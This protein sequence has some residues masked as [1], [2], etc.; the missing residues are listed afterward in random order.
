MAAGV[1]SPQ[2]LRALQVAE[3]AL[4]PQLERQLA[5]RLT[6]VAVAV[7]QEPVEVLLE[8][9]DRVLWSLSIQTQLAFLT[10]AAV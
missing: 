8:P 1:V 10:R 5:E 7:A 2:I 4:D 3:V 9:V 6:P